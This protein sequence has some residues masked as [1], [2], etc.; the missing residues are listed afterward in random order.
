MRKPLSCLLLSLILL[1]SLT[2]CSSKSSKRVEIGNVPSEIHFNGEV[3]K[4]TGEK[5]TAIGKKIGE[6][7]TQNEENSKE[8]YEVEGTDS[9][10]KVAVKMLNNT[11]IIYSLE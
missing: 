2:G 1:L 5:V 6:T 9:A 7:V 4:T 8:V 11:F 10:Q 3:Y